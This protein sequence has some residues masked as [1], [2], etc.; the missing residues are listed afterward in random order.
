M[1]RRAFI[2][3]VTFALVF[4]GF[5]IG[6]SIAV[7]ADGGGGSIGLTTTATYSQDF[8]TLANGPDP[9]GLYTTLPAGWRISESGT[10]SRNDGKYAIGTGSSTTGDTYSFGAATG[11]T[12]RA[13]GQLRSGSLISVIGAAFTNRMSLPITKLDVA[14]TGE[15]WR[16]GAVRTGTADRMDFQYSLDATSL[17]TGT[18]IDVDALDLTS[19]ITTGTAGLLNGNLPA[20]RRGLSATIVANVPA[21]GTV[22]IRWTDFDVPSSDDGL[23]IDDFTLKPYVD[24]TAPSVTVTSPFAG[25]VNVDLD[26]TIRITFSEPVDV[27]GAWSTLVCTDSGT[28][29]TTISGGPITFILDPDADFT[30]DETC[31]V[32]V[33]AAQVT[34]R[35]AFDPPDHPAADASFSFGTFA[36][37]T[38][39]HAIQGAAHRSPLEGQLVR[40]TVGVVTALRAAGFYLQDPAADADPATSEGV[41]VFTT[42]APVVHVGDSISVRASVREFRPG[43]ES[44]GN[45]TTTELASPSIWVHSTGNDLPAPIIIGADRTPPTANIEDDAS[46][47]NVETSGVFDPATDGIDFWESLEGMR[48]EIPDPAIVSPS[49][50]YNEIGVLANDGAGATGRTARGGIAISAT[51]KN[52]ERIIVDD[53]VLKLLGPSLF[54]THLNVGD[55]FVGSI[56]GVVDYDFGNFMVELT[57]AA[58]ATSGGLTREVTAAP[59][60]SELTIA[61]FNVENLDPGDHTFGTMASLIVNNLRSPDLISLEEI[62]DNNGETDNGTVDATTTLTMLRDAVVAAGGPTYAW[63]EIDPVNDRD[64]GAPGGNIRQVFFYRTDRGLEFVA[65]PGA[66][67]T[68]ANAVVDVSGGPQLQYS[69]GRIDPTNTAFTSSRK[70]LAGEFTYEGHHLFVIANHFNS[71]GGDEPLWGRDQPPVL[72]S[73]IQRTQQAAIVAAFVGDIL[74]LDAN[75][76]VVVL[77]DL[78]DFEFSGPV[79][80]LKAAGLHDLIETLPANERYSYVFEGNSQTLDHILT[81]GSLLPLATDDVVHVNSEFWDQASDHDPQVVRLFLP[82]LASLCSATRSVVSEAGVAGSLCAKLNA[83]KASRARGD[84]HAFAG[85]IGAFVNEVDAQRGK[86]ISDADATRL[87]AAAGVL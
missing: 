78:N 75:A 60:A 73:E 56:V 2:A 58:T 11:D 81:S 66:A 4:V 21:G 53:E 41:F 34:D 79:N 10:G 26:A 27:S 57:Q 22:F 15:Q 35:D 70:P 55:H 69:P 71:K 9:A 32:T 8:N 31:T 65:R 5:P 29:T 28:H 64:G 23:A 51:D 49:N 42:S 7:A 12:E 14:Y 3:L 1:A 86:A 38:P 46:S 50:S 24:D 30:S 72:S 82:D 13:F 19:P 83:A 67:S 54:P 47:G 52:P 40:N 18:W 68:T 87:I 36:A 44:T 33:L 17:T 6:S 25:A 45:L 59:A 20:N 39:I 84:D 16:L 43:G 63:S 80:A 85:Q 37:V 48:V 61:T 76:E 74:T 62:Q 77:G